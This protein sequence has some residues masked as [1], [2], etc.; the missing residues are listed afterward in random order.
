[1]KDEN[2]GVKVL[3][4]RDRRCATAMPGQF[5]MLWIPDVDEIPL[6]V[7]DADEHGTVAVAVKKVGDATR[8]LHS[9]TVGE[10]L[11]VRGPF[12]NW[13]R[14]RRGRS[15]MVG[16]GTGV[17]PL[18]FLT[19]KLVSKRQ[20]VTF[21]IGAKTEKELILMPELEGLC[22]RRNLVATTEDGSR[23]LRCLAT[24]PLEKMLAEEKPDVIYTCGPEQMM[25]KVFDLGEEK[26]VEVEASLERLMRCAVGLC[27]SCIIGKYRVCRDGPVFA[28]ERLREVKSELGF[29]KRGFDGSTVPL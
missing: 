26:G 17:A 27:G 15:L 12:G 28:S 19:K 11:G 29:S 4:F 25:R 9:M 1:V 7:L 24:E 18:L 22:S 21:V 2:P 20:G 8:A 14:M 13:F 6:S 3:T 10:L 23:G 5:L 16:G